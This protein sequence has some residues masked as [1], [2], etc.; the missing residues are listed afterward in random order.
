[1]DIKEINTNIPSGSRVYDYTLGGS[2][3]FEADRQ[4]AEYMFSLLPSTPK[5]VRLLR[6]FMQEAAAR[7]GEEGFDKFL[8]LGSGLPTADHIHAILPNAR[9]IYTDF[10]PVTVTYGQELVKNAPNV[11]FLEADV[12]NLDSILHSPFVNELFGDDLR[13]AIGLNGMTCFFE[14]EE[15]QQIFTRLYDWAAPGSKLFCT[16]ETKNPHLTTPKLEQFL[17]MFAQMGSPYYFLTPE[18][19]QTLSHPW[20]IEANAYKPITE[21]LDMPDLIAAEDREG[22]ELEFYGAILVK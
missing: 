11:R 6:S 4:A 10:D 3:N 20:R 8:D 9:I 22:V 17:G 19:S 2:H 15:L 18:Q 13:V 7:L 16:F 14:E 21:W 1:M 5:W 12:R